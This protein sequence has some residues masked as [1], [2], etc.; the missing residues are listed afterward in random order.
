MRGVGARSGYRVC[1]GFEAR[2]SHFRGASTPAVLSPLDGRRPLYAMRGPPPRTVQEMRVDS[3]LFWLAVIGVGAA[4][5]AA[6][7]VWALCRVAAQAD[8]AMGER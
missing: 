6:L 1:A 4:L 5:L 8:D 3:G 7:E 2:R